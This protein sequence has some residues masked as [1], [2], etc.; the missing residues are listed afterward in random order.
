MGKD[1]SDTTIKTNNILVMAPKGPPAR[2]LR[3]Q[4]A[5]C[6]GTISQQIQPLDTAVEQ[7]THF[8]EVPI[9]SILEVSSSYE[10]RYTLDHPLLRLSSFSR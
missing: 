3:V 1:I 8:R 5:H 9:T 4:M 7:V 2:V 6:M 10:Y